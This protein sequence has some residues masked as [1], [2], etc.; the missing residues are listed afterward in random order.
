MMSTAPPFP[1]TRQQ[2]ARLQAYI[3]THRQYAFSSLL[4]SVARNTTLRVLQAIQGKV[5]EA[6]DQQTPIVHVLF[7]R[8]ERA[9]LQSVVSEL[10]LYY[11]KQPERA[12]RIA[13]LNDLAALKQSLMRYEYV[14]QKTK[15]S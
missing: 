8:E 9:V 12:E 1:I 7:S 13:A 10:L 3:Q 6:M 4:P 11:A 2:A 14:T 5:I 15:L